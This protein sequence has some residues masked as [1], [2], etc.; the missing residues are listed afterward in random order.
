MITAVLYVLALIC[1]G[2]AAI[3]YKPLGGKVHPGWL[4]LLLFAL[5]SWAP[6]VGPIR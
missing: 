4:G 2:I 3:D 5:A 6:W 1:L